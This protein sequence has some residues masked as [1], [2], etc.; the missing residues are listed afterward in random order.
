MFRRFLI[1]GFLSAL[2]F[3][4]LLL[5][6][7]EKKNELKWL[8]FEKA[9]ESSKK[10]KKLI[11]VYLNSS[12][13]GWCRRFE[14]QTLANEAVKEKLSKDFIVTKINTGSTE[15]QTFQGKEVTERQL[16][17]MFSVRGVP[18]SA[19]VDASADSMQLITKLPG[20]M[21]ADQFAALLKFMGEGWYKNMSYQEFLESEQKLQKTK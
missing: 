8:T 4:C 11:Y 19:F 17:M 6:Q 2:M 5:A 1:I 7:S 13:C 10:Q 21:P 3:P 12:T 9:M 15:K 20:F 16:G 14:S 18:T